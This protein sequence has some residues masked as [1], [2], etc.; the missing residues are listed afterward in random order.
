MVYL[1]SGICFFGCSVSITEN[2]SQKSKFLRSMQ[3]TT[4]SQ[5]SENVKWETLPREY[6]L[7]YL[8]SSVRKN[9]ILF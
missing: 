8:I 7:L 9:K 1:L 4:F 3:I 5:L 2:W 6:E